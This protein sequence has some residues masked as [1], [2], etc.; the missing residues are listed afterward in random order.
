MKKPTYKRKKL[1]VSQAIQG[2]LLRRMVFYWIFFQ[3]FQWHALF[4][5]GGITGVSEPRPFVEMY[6]GF[7][8]NHVLLFAVGLSALPI[9]IWDM[10][11]LSNRIAGPFVQFER[12]LKQMTRGERAEP[13]RLRKGDLVTEFQGVFNEFVESRNQELDAGDDAAL[14]PELESFIQAE[15]AAGNYESADEVI[16]EAIRLLQDC[17]RES[18]PEDLQPA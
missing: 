16:R 6:L 8:S 13:V 17:E 18:E 5:S 10:L 15:V 12:V 1:F 11:K 2:R 7:L 14:T 4:L 9:L 3:L